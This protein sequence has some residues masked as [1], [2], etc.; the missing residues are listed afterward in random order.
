VQE[1][2]HPFEGECF[3]MLGTI[4]VEHGP[5]RGGERA[6]SSVVIGLELIGENTQLRVTRLGQSAVPDG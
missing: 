1:R 2:V 6:Y 5:D 4:G 3:G